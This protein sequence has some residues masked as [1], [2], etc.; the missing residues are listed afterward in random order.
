MSMIR[1]SSPFGE[2]L[3][4]RQAM[5]R[6]FEESYVRP[7]GGSSGEAEGQTLALDIYDT[8]EAIVVEAALPGVR[9]DDVE[10]TATGNTLTI[11]GR[12]STERKTDESGYYFQEIRRGTFSRTVTLPDNVRTDGASANFENGLLRLAIPKAEETKPRQIPISPT[13]EGSARSVGSGTGEGAGMQT[14]ASGN[15]QAGTDGGPSTWGPETAHS[16]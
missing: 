1:R 8:P 9:P 16:V 2:L 3:S 7:R 11:T 5:D 12:H 14:E 13:T 4:L 10:I 15:A 6:L